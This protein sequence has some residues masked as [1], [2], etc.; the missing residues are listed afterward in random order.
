MKQNSRNHLNRISDE[1][2]VNRFRKTGDPGIIGELYYRYVH[3][4]YGVSMKFLKDRE[5][6]RDAT[7]QVFES[8]FNKLKKQEIQKFRSWLYV[9]TKN[10]CLMILRSKSHE[11]TWDETYQLADEFMDFDNNM[12]PLGKEPL[13]S[14][15]QVLNKCIESLSKNQK[16]CIQL[17]YYK[18]KCYKEI[19]VLKQ[20]KIKKVKSYIQN[21][22]RNLKNCIEKLHAK[23]Q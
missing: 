2:L 18:K 3:L 14:E 8:L 4:V 22:K 11:S 21:G 5:E 13:D 23:G 16:E 17:F 9:I 15:H 6:S 10:H 20:Y 7:M 1:K 12:H 19:A